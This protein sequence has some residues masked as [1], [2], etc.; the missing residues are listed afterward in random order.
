MKKTK[1][2]TI[3]LITIFAIIM[4]LIVYK[5]AKNSAVRQ[6]TSVPK[7]II[8]L[9]SSAAETLYF[10]KASEQIVG[11]TNYCKWPLELTQ[12]PVVGRGF[13]DLNL[14]AIIGLEPDIIFCWEGRDEEIL[15]KKGFPIFLIKPL[16]IYGVMDQI[17]RI[18]KTI[19]KEV[20]AEKLISDMKEQINLIQL[21]TSHFKPR[22]KTKVYLEGGSKFSTRA[23]GSLAGSLIKLAGGINIAKNSEI[24]YPTLNNEY[25]IQ[26]N[27]DVII[28]SEYGASVAEIKSRPGWETISAIK[29]NRVYVQP[30]YFNYYSPRCIEGLKAYAKWFYPD[31][32]FEV[33]GSK[34]EVRGSKCEVGKL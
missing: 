13:G 28:V 24:A 11:I 23:T 27:P 26:S 21:Q 5:P 12:K 14:E 29:N 15:K 22:T 2:L 30:S 8:A 16:D 25:I 4:L 3:S 32:K 17:K 1:L 7:R 18:G 19:N 9:A 6:E 20:V 34:F 33:R 31:I 10:L